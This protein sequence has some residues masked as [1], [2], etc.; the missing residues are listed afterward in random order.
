MWFFLRRKRQSHDPHLAASEM[1]GTHL[2]GSHMSGSDGGHT[3]GTNT[4]SGMYVPV[5]QSKIELSGEGKPIH[6]LQSLSSTPG[7]QHS[8]YS[9]SRTPE[10][11]SN[12]HTSYELP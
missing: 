10:L 1:S 8:H 7:Y 5:R 3:D 2:S 11:Q 6:E 12:N 9:D 4:P